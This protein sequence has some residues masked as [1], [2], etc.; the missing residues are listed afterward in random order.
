[1]TTAVTLVAVV[2]CTLD[3]VAMTVVDDADAETDKAIVNLV[4][5]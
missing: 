1:M 3:D 5:V 2:V 4:A